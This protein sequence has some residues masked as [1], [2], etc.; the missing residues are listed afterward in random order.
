[1]NSS[2]IATFW[3]KH[4]N[5]IKPQFVFSPLVP[6]VNVIGH[7]SA[8]NQPLVEQAEK[9]PKLVKA[10][11]P[12]SKVTTEGSSKAKAKE[13]VPKTRA[14]AAQELSK[15]KT[16]AKTQ[17]TPATEGT[18]G[19]RKQHT[20]ARPKEVV[21]KKETVEEPVKEPEVEKKK[22]VIEELAKE[23]GEAIF[24]GDKNIE[25][26]DNGAAGEEEMVE[27]QEDI[28]EEEE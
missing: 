11:A 19:K 27:D 28:A 6:I 18:K 1:M 15:I 22:K 20:V 3:Q 10:E 7:N 8:L 23:E 13:T 2:N 5:K 24:W 16:R 21:E 17:A 14:N 12:S 9:K 25:M 4:F 26:E